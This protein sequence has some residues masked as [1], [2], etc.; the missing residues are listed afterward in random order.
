MSIATRIENMSNNIKNAYD[1]L[2]DLGLD[3]NNVNKNLENLS[4]QIDLIYDELPQVEDEGTQITLEPTKQAKMVLKLNGNSYQKQYTGKNLWFFSNENWFSDVAVASHNII[5]VN[6]LEVTSTSHTY[7]NS[8]FKLELSNGTYTFKL[9]KVTNSN[10]DMTTKRMT[11]VKL[12]DSGQRTIVKHIDEGTPQTIEISNN[13]NNFYAIEFWSSYDTALVNTAKFELIQIE[14]GSSTTEY[15]P[16]VGKQ[17]SPNI[18]YPQA[19]QVVN[20]DNIIKKTGENLFDSSFEERTQYSITHTYENGIITM[21]GTSNGVGFVGLKTNLSN[22]IGPGDN[23]LVFEYIS[24]TQSGGAI[25]FSFGNSSM[26]PTTDDENRYFSFVSPSGNTSNILQVVN[27]A[28]TKEITKWGVYINNNCVFNN[29]KFRI[30]IVPGSYT[31]STI[32]E[33]T[34]YQKYDY[35][36]NLWDSNIFNNTIMTPI[37]TG[38]YIDKDGN[39]GS[40]NEFSVYK[41]NIKPNLLYKIINSGMS[42]APGVAIYDENDNYID[43]FKYDQKPILTYKM[44]SN[45]KYILYSVVTLPSSPRYDANIYSIQEEFELCKIGDYQDYFYKQNNNWYKYKK[46]NK[47]ILNGNEWYTASSNKIYSPDIKDYL[48]E[49]NIPISD[50]FR[51]VS[52]KNSIGEMTINNTIAFNKNNDISRLYIYNTNFDTAQKI[53][54]WLST[55][56]TTIYYI[57]ENA[58]QIQIT[59]SE[60]IEQLNIIAR[61]KSFEDQ[62]NLLQKNAGLPFIIEATALKKNS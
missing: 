55:H 22:L 32:P 44:P 56:N 26:L 17:P 23:T 40:N 9:G 39:Y 60:L 16:Y 34:A 46:I 41:S 20:G 36:L 47:I 52:N 13:D 49:N 4:S 7:A 6:S 42:A 28:N 11:L 12:T 61:A 25:R 30:Y 24:G 58:E 51:G 43:G 57:L 50:Y 59:N 14:Q 1:S 2:D 29:Y 5:N 37:E 31:A 3:L 15:E 27:F 10:P 18:D 21:N 48:E 35:N 45:A 8:K 54:A 38:K 53:K 19:I 33:Y 62:T